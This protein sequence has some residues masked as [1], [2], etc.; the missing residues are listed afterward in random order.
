V[1]RDRPAGVTA[2]SVFFAAG[3]AIAATAAVS[4]LAPGGALEA[5]WRLNRRGRAALGGIGAWAV[6]LLAT[7][8]VACALAAAGLWRGDRRGHRLAFGMIALNLVAAAAN[9]IVG[10]DLRAAAGIPIAAAMLAFL[11]SR[12]VRVFFARPAGSEEMGD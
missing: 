11:R 4:L 1:R 5:M 12:R 2:L 10:R 8:A 6:V 3:A 7:V 9:A